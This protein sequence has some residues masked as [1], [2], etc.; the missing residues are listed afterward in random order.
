MKRKPLALSAIVAL[1]LA[2]AT[3]K[4]GMGRSPLVARN[5]HPALSKRSKTP[6]TCTSMG[7][8]W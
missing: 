2:L 8:H 3:C 5:R 4:S 7:I 1:L 6:W